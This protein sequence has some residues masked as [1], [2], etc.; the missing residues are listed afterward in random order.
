MKQWDLKEKNALII[1]LIVIP[2]M[3]ITA[4]YSHMLLVAYSSI[5]IAAVIITTIWE[6]L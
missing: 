6:Y 2:I 1:Y 4:W 3:F 5:A